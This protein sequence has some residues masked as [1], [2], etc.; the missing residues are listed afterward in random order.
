MF[1]YYHAA[2]CH[3]TRCLL[4]LALNNDKKKKYLFTISLVHSIISSSTSSS[5]KEKKKHRILTIR[6]SFKIKTLQNLGYQKA[7]YIY[8]CSENYDSTILIPMNSKSS[9]FDEI[10]R[11]LSLKYA[12]FSIETRKSDFN[13]TSWLEKELDRNSSET[14]HWFGFHCCAEDSEKFEFFHCSQ[15]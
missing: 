4:D 13:D 11:N 5:S 8:Y 7:S 6:S 12:F 10:W 14:T 3:Q 15:T 9:K 1:E 2:I